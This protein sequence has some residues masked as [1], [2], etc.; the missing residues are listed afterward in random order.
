M[1][2]I[3]AEPSSWSKHDMDNGDAIGDFLLGS[4]EITLPR[5]IRG[6]TGDGSTSRVRTS[7]SSSSS[8]FR[9]SRDTLRSSHSRKGVTWAAGT[10]PDMLQTPSHQSTSDLP[11]AAAGSSGF[12]STSLFSVDS[13]RGSMPALAWKGGEDATDKDS[14]RRSGLTWKERYADATLPYHSLPS[15]GAAGST[16][17]LTEKDPDLEGSSTHAQSRSLPQS[18]SGPEIPALQTQARSLPQSRAG[19]KES[20]TSP[21]RQ[22]PQQETPSTL[23]TADLH[24]QLNL[25]RER[26]WTEQQVSASVLVC[27]RIHTYTLEHKHDTHKHTH[28]HT[29][30]GTCLP[31]FS[32]CRDVQ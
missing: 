24:T 8:D 25:L 14:L 4:E 21:L 22:H 17:S 9:T 31:Y 29:H 6:R 12:G 13:L 3:S 32:S 5:T 18:R 2:S 1:R 15:R 28:T 19:A 11:S 16:S 7:I 27:R 26:S 20:R 30:R 10:L 23:S